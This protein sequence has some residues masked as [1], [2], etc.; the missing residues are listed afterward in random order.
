MKKTILTGLV[1]SVSLLF[2]INKKESIA[3]YGGDEFQNP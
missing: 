1:L 2:T 3:I